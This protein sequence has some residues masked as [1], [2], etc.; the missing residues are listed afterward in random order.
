MILNIQI[1]ILIYIIIVRNALSKAN[2]WNNLISN[3]LGGRWDEQSINENQW[4][5][6]VYILLYSIDIVY[7]TLAH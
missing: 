6:S 3:W 4:N 1:L 7:A 2:L 5:H